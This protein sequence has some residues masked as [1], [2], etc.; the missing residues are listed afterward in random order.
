MA[1]RVAPELAESFFT[2]WNARD[3]YGWKEL[4]ERGAVVSLPAETKVKFL[5]LV[6]GNLSLVR[7]LEGEREGEAVYVPWGSFEFTGD[8]TAPWPPR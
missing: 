3:P 5:K 6:S 1:V 7:V 8:D 2:T 4:V